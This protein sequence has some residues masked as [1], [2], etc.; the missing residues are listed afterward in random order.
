[1][2]RRID[3]CD[4][5]QALVE[6]AVIAPVLLIILMGVIDFGRFAYDGIVLANAATAGV[7]YGAQN[8]VNASDILGMKN[9]ANTDCQSLCGTGT[10]ARFFTTA[11][12]GSTTV[13][14]SYVEVTTSATYAPI[15]AYPGIPASIPLQRTADRQVSP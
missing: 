15:V 6:A 1:M 3:R 7:Q 11:M 5:G 10:S 13:R 8:F 2:S 12:P 14:R 9:A 4:A